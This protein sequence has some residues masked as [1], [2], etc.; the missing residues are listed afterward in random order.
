M[1][2]ILGPASTNLGKQIA[3]TLKAETVPV[4]FKI[5]P[6]GEN[7]LRLEGQLQDKDVA[8]VQTT[9]PPQDS[10]LIQLALMADSAKRNGARKITAIVP[11]LAYARQDK[12]FL[13]GESISAETIA[14]MLGAAGVDQLITVNV[15]QDKVLS[16]FP[17]PAKS[18]SAVPLL[19]EY[20]VNKGYA[21]AFALSPDKGAIHIAEEARKVLGGEC[22]YLEKNRDRFTGQVGMERK[23]LDV[24]GKTVIIFD[25]IISSGGT[26]VAAAKILK[27]L[28]P[29]R[30]YVA[31]VHALLIG[32]A[33]RLILQTGVE[34]IVGTDSVP[35][36]VS[37]VSLA[38]L[39]SRE[40]AG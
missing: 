32:E 31:A 11:Y 6:D 37:K 5:F 7:Y 27:E 3:Q 22:G 36:S 9:S 1:K 33:E 35:S 10:R 24:K 40:L 30:I 13:Q 14:R 19:A 25:D 4:A 16:H 12:V 23:T 20:F 38:P 8:I 21:K 15:H 34:E 39:I 17:F 2:I 26:I 28:N 29:Q 18:V